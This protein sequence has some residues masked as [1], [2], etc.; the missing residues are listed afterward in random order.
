MTE[1]ARDIISRGITARETTSVTRIGSEAEVR[2]AV[3]AMGHAMSDQNHVPRPDGT[4]R[5]V[6]TLGGRLEE[7]FRISR[8]REVEV[9]AIETDKAGACDRRV[10]VKQRGG[11]GN[12]KGDQI[13]AKEKSIGI[14][15]IKVASLDIS[16]ETGSIED[17]SRARGSRGSHGQ[18]IDID[19]RGREI[20]KTLNNGLSESGMRV[21]SRG[22]SWSGIGQRKRGMRQ[23]VKV[24]VIKH[25][26]VVI[27]VD[28]VV[29]NQDGQGGAI[30][31]NLKGQSS[32]KTGRA[33]KGAK[34]VLN[35]GASVEVTEN[36]RVDNGRDTGEVSGAGGRGG[37]LSGKLGIEDGHTL[38]KKV[39][40]GIIH[41]EG[42][43]DIKRV[44]IAGVEVSTGRRTILVIQEL[45][46]NGGDRIERSMEEV[47][48]TS[49][50][51]RGERGGGGRKEQRLEAKRRKLNFMSLWWW[52]EES[53]IVK[54]EGRMMIDSCKEED[55]DRLLRGGRGQKSVIQRVTEEIALRRL[56]EKRKKIS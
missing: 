54:Y 55:D 41:K 34:L 5:D 16:G 20:S 39:R 7:T 46:V 43:N 38:G 30:V 25:G 53:V 29:V 17:R 10:E 33:A 6:K 47:G 11:T 9:G 36:K 27:E 22:D 48:T 23:M 18:S 40:L 12:S 31:L 32:G 24:E 8:G 21:P 3:I 13:G 42:S 45:K 19:N 15:I 2:V 52:S 44:G 35:T 1:A 51:E 56:K 4:G 37:E 50:D 28:G 49:H 14:N 26:L